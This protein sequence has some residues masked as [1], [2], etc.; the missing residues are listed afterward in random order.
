MSN[1]GSNTSIAFSTKADG[2]MKRDD[3]A[4]DFDNLEKFLLSH[5]L[6]SDYVSM[7]QV[8]GGNV[9]VVYDN[10][11]KRIEGVDGLVTDQS[12]INLCIVTADC[13][14]ILLYDN[15][16]KIIGAAHAGSKGLLQN[17]IHNTVSEFKNHFKSNPEDIHI[18][19]GPNIEQKC[20]EVGEEMIAAFQKQ[21]DWFDESLFTNTANNRYLLDLRKIAEH[22]L[23]KEGILKANINISDQCTKCSVNT[24]YSYRKGDKTG[25]FVSVISLV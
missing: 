17:I 4:I 8:H 24:V 25:R 6:P 21:F 14:P 20:Y 23:L 11:Q 9:E 2:S 3:G 1:T 7:G 22:C 13:L 19:V 18:I 5:N 16:K 12:R 10:Q 15:K